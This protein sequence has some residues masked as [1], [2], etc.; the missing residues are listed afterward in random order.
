MVLAGPNDRSLALYRLDFIHNSITKLT[1]PPPNGLG[2]SW[3]SGAGS[4]VVVA[5]ASQGGRD[6]LATLTNDH[7]VPITDSP[8]SGGQGPAVRSDGLILY[9]LPIPHVIV[10]HQVI[11]Y[12]SEIHEYNLVTHE[13]RLVLAGPDGLGVEGWGPGG[14]WAYVEET[15]KPT[16]RSTLIVRAADGSERRFPFN[17]AIGAV[18][19]PTASAIAVFTSGET[20]LLDPATGTFGPTFTGWIASAWSP[21]GKTLLLHRINQFRLGLWH[22]GD[23]EPR[24]FGAFTNTGGAGGVASAAWLG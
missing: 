2:A 19:S 17:S 7:L 13:D 5:D 6:R 8:A 18:W 3:L 20:R 21:D 24:S 4:W 1:N 16:T 14:S 15:Y 12:T 22:V 11:N 10:P 9:S 23:P